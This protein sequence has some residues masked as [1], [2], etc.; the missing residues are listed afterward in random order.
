[1]LRLTAGS[2]NFDATPVLV[3]VL[4]AEAEAGRPSPEP[5]AR[6]SRCSAPPAAGAGARA[7]VLRRGR[8]ATPMA[9]RGLGCPAAFMSELAGRRYRVRGP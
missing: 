5:P 9:G 4:E 6:R 1:M 7:T 8:R 2:A 3:E